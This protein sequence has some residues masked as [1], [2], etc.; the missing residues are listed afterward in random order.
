MQIKELIVNLDS[1]IDNLYNTKINIYQEI[2]KI[3]PDINRIYTDFM[4][5]IP[6][7]NEI[8]M[9]ISK[10]GIVSQISDFA[11]ALETQDKVGMYDSLN[12]EIKDTLL[13]YE[14]ILGIMKG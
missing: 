9:D 5:L 8:G 4:E 10:D 7:L 13:F 1:I 12:F 6:K 3:F 2:N 14:E 11:T